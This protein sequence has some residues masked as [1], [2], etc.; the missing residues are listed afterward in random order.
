MM[1]GG[2]KKSRR[3]FNQRL[4]QAKQCFAMVPKADRNL[5]RLPARDRDK[6]R[7]TFPN[8]LADSDHPIANRDVLPDAIDDVLKD[9]AGAGAL[10]EP[11]NS[12]P[13]A[14]GIDARNLHNADLIVPIVPDQYRTAVK[15]TVENHGISVMGKHFIAKP[16]PHRRRAREG[17]L[18]RARLDVDFAHLTHAAHRTAFTARVDLLGSDFTGQR[19]S[20]NVT[21][22]C[23]GLGRRL[24][25]FLRCRFWLAVPCPDLPRMVLGDPD[26]LNIRNPPG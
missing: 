1:R 19:P 17:K 20:D 23:R 21:R 13:D 9:L 26:Q 10:A 4:S 24:D 11:N 2:H 25:R 14:V 12:A 15:Q 16:A 8:F 5:E 7:L 6:V 18:D 3:F 22:L